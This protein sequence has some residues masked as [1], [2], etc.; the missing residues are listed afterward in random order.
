MEE[1]IKENRSL[2]IEMQRIEKRNRIKSREQRTDFRYT[3]AK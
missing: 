3:D 1:I 2:K